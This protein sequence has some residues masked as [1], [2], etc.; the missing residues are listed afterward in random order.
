MNVVLVEHHRYRAPLAVGSHHVARVLRER[1]HRVIWVSHPRTLLHRLLGKAWPAPVV[2]HPD[3]VVEVTPRAR[4]PY[5]DLPLLGSL[6]WGKRWLRGPALDPLV[7]EVERQ[8]GVDLLWLSDFTMLP[9]LDRLEPGKVLLRFFDHL[10]PFRWMPRSIYRLVIHYL[11]RVDLTV[12]SSRSLVRRLEERGIPA[13]YLPNGAHVREG[14]RVDGARRPLAVYVGAIESWFDARAVETWARALPDV[15]FRIVGPNG[16]GLSSKLPNLSYP[17]PMPYEE[18][19]ELLSQAR[20][21][22]IPFRLDDLTRGVHP[23]KL[24]DYLAH[25]CP[26]L[27]AALPEVTPDERGVSVYHS[28]EEGIDVLRREMERPRPL[29]ERLALRQLARDNR[30][31]RRLDVALDLLGPGSAEDRGRS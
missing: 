23:L 3:G 7:E 17:G 29:E 5:V 12:A 8:G 1:G 4:L 21:G 31:E 11:S 27:S 24:Y 22:L 26:V 30:W 6:A 20:C 2:R 16:A 28:A 25:G 10:D 18:L 13:R 9:M 15:E 14:A 19:P